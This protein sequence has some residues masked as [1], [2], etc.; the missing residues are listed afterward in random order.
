MEEPEGIISRPPLNSHLADASPLTPNCPNGWRWIERRWGSR[1]ASQT[2]SA[3]KQLCQYG[4]F[5][6]AITVLTA[7]SGTG[8]A[9]QVS[10]EEGPGVSC[11]EASV[12]ATHCH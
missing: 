5:A 9:Q 1:F 11:D 10:W 3:R 12:S 2:L 4:D 7:F 8:G 6:H